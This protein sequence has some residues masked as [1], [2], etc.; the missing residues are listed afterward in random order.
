[1]L[2]GVLFLTFVFIV[3]FNIDSILG[4][5]VHSSQCIEVMQQRD[6]R[7]V[8]PLSVLQGKSFAPPLALTQD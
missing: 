7:P 4:S 3:V 1:M 5:T 6:V 2:V 8:P